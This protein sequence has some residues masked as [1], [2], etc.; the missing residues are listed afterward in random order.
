MNS[1]ARIRANNKYKN[2][3]LKNGSIKQLNLTLKGE[4]YQMIDNYSKETGISKAQ[5]ITDAVK[6]YISHHPTSSDNS[7]KEI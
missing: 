7:E 1:E 5:L 3:M 2:K 6:E 4:V